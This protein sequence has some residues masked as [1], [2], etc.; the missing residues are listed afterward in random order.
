[1]TIAPGERLFCDTNVLLNAVDRRRALNGQALRVLNQLPNQGVEL[2]VS[3]QVLREYLAVSTRPRGA[4][5]LGQSVVEALEN[6]EAFAARSTV[7]DE[8]RRVSE[9]LVVLVRRLGCTGKQVHDANIVATMLAHGVSKLVTDNSADFRS[10]D[11]VEVLSL[12]ELTA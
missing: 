5:G 6:V 11:G 8:T 2:C 12:A 9:Q 1:M 7:L 3:G 4:N 10:F